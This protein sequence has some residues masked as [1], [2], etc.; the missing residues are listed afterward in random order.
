MNI[1]YACLI[2]GDNNIKYK[3]CKLKNYNQQKLIEIIGYNL[4]MLDKA[5][6]YNIKNNIKLFRISSDII[7]LA[8]H[9]I[10]NINWEII[11]MD[12]LKKIGIKIKNNRMRV[13]MHPGQYTVL[14]SPTQ[15]VVSKA[16]LDLKYHTMFLDTL[17][18]NSEAKIILHIGGVY[19]DKDAAIARFIANYNKL[20]LNIKKR[21]VIENDDKS[22]NINDILK[23]SEIIN[24]PVVYD[25]LHNKINNYDSTKSDRYWINK[26]SKTWKKGDGTQK[27]HYSQQD[28]NKK[29]GS[30]SSTIDIIEFKKFYNQIKDMNIDIM[31][32]VKDKD[33]SAIKCIEVVKEINNMKGK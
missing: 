33:M 5:I 31:L 14:N 12:K 15:S 3:S 17:E 28:D 4:D 26:C 20:D 9:E 23:I 19:G 7:P 10:M 24:I 21:L 18:L 22:Y 16:I 11:F 25:N 32:E 8:S 30:H 27:I 1:G 6:D 13:S 29:S 2:V